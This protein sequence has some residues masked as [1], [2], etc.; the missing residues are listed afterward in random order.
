MPLTLLVVVVVS[1]ANFHVLLFYSATR[2]FPVFQ[3]TSFSFRTKTHMHT[4]TY[5]TCTTNALLRL[6]LFFSLLL[7][8][9]PHWTRTRNC[10]CRKEN[11]PLSSLTW[12]RLARWM[13]GEKPDRCRAFS[14]VILCCHCVCVR[15]VWFSLA[16]FALSLS[17]SFSIKYTKSRA[18]GFFIAVFFCSSLNNFVFFAYVSFGVVSHTLARKNQ[19]AEVVVF[20]NRSRDRTAR[21]KSVTSRDLC[22]EEERYAHVE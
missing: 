13:F 15:F 10:S 12:T 8:A 2:R 20:G 17:F 7:C 3:R 9:V 11:A 4:R 14:F 22:L 18:R 1:F 5:C 6:K 21:M 19:P 16:R